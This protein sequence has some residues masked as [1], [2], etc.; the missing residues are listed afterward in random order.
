MD[1]K[2]VARPK[3]PWKINCLV[4]KKPR[5]TLGGEKKTRTEGAFEK[6]KRV[7]RKKKKD[8]GK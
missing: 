6:T 7:P 1:R 8:V 3:R 4:E 5:G 2:K